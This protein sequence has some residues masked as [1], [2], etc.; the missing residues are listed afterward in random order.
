MTESNQKKIK[1]MTFGDHPFLPSGVGTQQRYICEALLKSGK[2]QIFSVGGAMNIPRE[3]EGRIQLVEGYGEDWKVMAVNGYGNPDLMRSL[4]HA[5]KPN[6]ISI[7]TDPRFWTWLFMMEH[8]VRR[9]V[10]IVF[11]TI[12]DNYPAPQF[13]RKYYESVDHLACINSV[14]YNVAKELCP[15]VDSCYLPHS[16][17]T[18]IF[19]KLDAEKVAEFKQGVIK[20]NPSFADKIIFM[21]NSRNARRKQTG[22]MI[23][24]FKQFL[25]I[26]GHDKAMFLM[27]TDPKDIHGQDLEVILEDFGLDKGQVV[28]SNAKIPPE[29]L[30]MLYNVADCTVQ[31][32]DAEGWGLSITES[33][34]CETPVI[35]TL[36]GG[37]VDQL[38][39]GEEW[40]GIGIEPASKSLIGSQ[41]VPYIFEDRLNGDNVVNAFLEMY[42]KTPDER[43]EMGRKGRQS[44]FNR[45]SFEDHG[46]RWVELLEEIHEKHGSWETRQNYKPYQVIEL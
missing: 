23:L 41:D 14:A 31:L 21:F 27:H 24:W 12:W 1:L 19:K 9:H 18:D 17:P 8:E 33:L 35:A 22:S 46:K 25:D 29:E 4:L 37:L 44:I 32:S 34:A 26:V 7:F 2:F 16:V 20:N 15:D 5:E 3:A 40:F 39:D 10:P 6:I 13:N 36:T 11:Y 30:A 28:I 42:N 43:A 45:L 38:T